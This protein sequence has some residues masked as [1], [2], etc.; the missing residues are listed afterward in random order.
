MDVLIVD[1]AKKCNFR[2]TFIGEGLKFD[3][4]NGGVSLALK[5]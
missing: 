2:S 4:G 5:E 3:I 1:E